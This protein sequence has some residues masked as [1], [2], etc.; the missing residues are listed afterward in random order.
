MTSMLSP[1]KYISSLPS[2]VREDDAD[3]CL[4]SANE[5]GPLWFR[6]RL[7]FA[8][9]GANESTKAFTAASPY[10]GSTSYTTPYGTVYSGYAAQSFP[11]YLTPF[12]SVPTT[13]GAYSGY[14]SPYG[15]AFNYGYTNPYGIAP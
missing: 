4:P 7:Y 10:S 6:V 9:S 15:S 12:G 8:G 3:P 1:D 5:Q 11:R 14:S 13:F 2:C